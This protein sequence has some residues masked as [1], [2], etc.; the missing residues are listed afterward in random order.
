M[1]N[2]GITERGDAGLDFE[3]ENHLQPGNIIISKSLNDKL[4]EKLVLHQKQCI[5]HMTCT[6]YGRTIVEPN[7]Q[8][9]KWTINQYS[10]LIQAGFPANQII[11][12]VDPIIPTEKGIKLAINVI[13]AYLQQCPIQNPRVRFSFL[14]MYPH[15]KQRF[16]EAK[17]SLPY[18]TFI[19]PYNLREKCLKE[20]R[21]LPIQLEA[22]AEN[23]SEKIGCISKKDYDTLNLDFEETNFQ[24]QRKDCA[25][26]CKKIE[27][28]NTPKQCAHKCLYCYWK[29]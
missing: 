22:C 12:R 28:L 16:L 26:C 8:P 3:W 2:F 29:Y 18:D 17:I 4:I 23:V 10:K 19:A 6:G 14:D 25:C 11:L 1:I 21:K 24:K 13:Q 7:V 20:L 9:F 15:V 5:F 27:L